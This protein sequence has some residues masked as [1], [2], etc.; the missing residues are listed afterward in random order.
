VREPRG[1]FDLRNFGLR[2][3]DP[4][5]FITK[6]SGAKFDHRA[7]FLRWDAFIGNVV[8]GLALV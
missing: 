2:P 6:M 5:D 7:E 3:H 1:T 4:A 8:V